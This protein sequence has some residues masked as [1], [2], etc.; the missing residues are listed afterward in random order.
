MQMRKMC[1]ESGHD[2]DERLGPRLQIA[3]ARRYVP[4]VAGSVVRLGRARRFVGGINSGAR[5]FSTRTLWV[6]IPKLR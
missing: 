1:G 5:F 2:G 3:P 6:G 4:V